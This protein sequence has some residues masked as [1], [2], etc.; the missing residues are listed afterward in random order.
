MNNSKGVQMENKNMIYAAVAVVAVIVIA[1]G[2]YTYMQGQSGDSELEARRALWEEWE[3]TFYMGTTST[4]FHP[5]INMGTGY[6]NSL[7]KHL[8]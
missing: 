8:S 6:M 5:G 7:A 1:Y 3:K 4:D 2:G